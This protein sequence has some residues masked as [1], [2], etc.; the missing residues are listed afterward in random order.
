[1]AKVFISYS[2]RDYIGDD[3]KVIGGNVIDKV[4]KSLSDH[5]VEFWIDREKLDPGETYASIIAN[6]ISNCDVF[7]FLSSANSNSSPWTLREI[8]M[9]ID[10]GK[11][12]LPVRLDNSKYAQPVALYLASIQYIDWHELGE[13]ESLER[14]VARVQGPEQDDGMRRFEKKKLPLATSCVIYA[15]IAFL[16][17]VYAVL[18]YQFLW[19]RS[20]RSDEI[21]GGLV[22][23][24][25]EFG[26]L[27]SIWYL[28]R[29]IRLRKSTFIFPAVV[30]VIVL[31]FGMLMNDPDIIWCSVLLFFGWIFVAIMCAVGDKRRKSFF[32]QMGREQIL[33]RATDPENLIFLYLLFKAI[34]IVWEHYRRLPGGY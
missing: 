21:M 20:L 24:A 14:I 2:K 28:V 16:T 22:G 10:S 8:S 19:A 7:L 15:G 23:Y 18:T 11:T 25:C 12:V 32:K 1:M 31:L 27:M 4:I 5:G 33:A 3:G 9:A 17:F 26:V 30:S 34:I 13:H 6:S 29:L